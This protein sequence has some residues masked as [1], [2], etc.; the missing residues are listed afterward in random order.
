MDDPA[1]LVAEDLEFDMVR[2]DDELLD[3]DGAVAK[4]LREKE[5]AD[6]P[7]L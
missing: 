3:I 7:L 1:V 2:V 6:I 4:R 5:V